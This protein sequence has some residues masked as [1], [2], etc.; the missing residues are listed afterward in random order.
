MKTR[1][2]S[3]IIA[4]LLLIA[5]VLSGQAVFAVVLF[6]LAVIGMR[7]FFK[8]VEQTGYKTVRIIG[9]LACI[10]VLLAGLN[11]TLLHID[12]AKVFQ[13]LSLGIFLLVVLLLSFIIF[14]H[15]KY[16]V[17]GIALTFFGVVYVVFP[18]T[19]VTVTRA[20]P[21]GLWLIW[22][23]FIGAF[24]TDTAAY[25]AGVFFGKRKILP[26]VSP[27][28]SLEGSIGGVLGCIAITVLYGLLLNSREIIGIIPVYHLILL[29]LFNGVISQIGDWA[30]SAI[31]RYV[32]IKDYGNLMP[33]HGGVLDRF[34]SILFTAPVVYFYFSLLVL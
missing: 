16:H 2:V 8:A 6:I 26:V 28:K 24:V 25:F 1:V 12:A 19:L 14:Q 10:A 20:L 33:G 29:G 31:K 5:V 3:G 13:G 11:G 32:K 17:I 9:Y 4:F 15:E 21:Q 22:F 30:A 7:E 27:K 18:F 34:D 23:I